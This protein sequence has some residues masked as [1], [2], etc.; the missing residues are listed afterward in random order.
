MAARARRQEHQGAFVDAPNQIL[1]YST[2]QW[3][4]QGSGVVTDIRGGT[5]LG[6]VDFT[7]TN[8]TVVDAN[9]RHPYSLNGQGAASVGFRGPQGN[10][11]RQLFTF[12]PRTFVDPTFTPPAQQT[13]F[14]TVPAADVTRFQQAFIGSTSDVCSATATI[15]LYGLAADANCGVATFGP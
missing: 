6:S 11:T 8:N 9:V 5:V 12:V 4:V 15:L 7:A 14:R 3:M 1:P 2:A 13:Q 10:L